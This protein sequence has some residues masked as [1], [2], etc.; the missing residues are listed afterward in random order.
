MSETCCWASRFIRRGPDV[1]VDRME[2]ATVTQNEREDRA[3]LH[4]YEAAHGAWSACVR[5]GRDMLTLE[6]HGDIS[7]ESQRKLYRDLESVR[8]NRG[9]K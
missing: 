8:A 6:L 1:R 5:E 9:V 2:D 3:Y 4:G 7:V